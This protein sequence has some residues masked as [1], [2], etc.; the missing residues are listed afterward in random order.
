MHLESLSYQL[1]PYGFGGLSGEQTLQDG[2]LE[3]MSGLG[4]VRRGLLGKPGLDAL[5]SRLILVFDFLRV[6][7]PQ[8]VDVLESV[9]R[10]ARLHLI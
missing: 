6:E 7:M 4:E 5:N 8:C 3:G 9:E 1:R 10:L 2:L